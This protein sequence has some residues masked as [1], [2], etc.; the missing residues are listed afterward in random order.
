MGIAPY[1]RKGR[2]QGAPRRPSLYDHQ[3][4][5]IYSSTEPAYRGAGYNRRVSNWYA[6]S[7]S[8]NTILEG[9]LSTLRPRCRDM[10]RKAPWAVSGIQGFVTS[11]VGT[12]VQ[13]LPQIEDRNLRKT[14]MD[15]WRFWND[16]E[17]DADGLD[18]FY[19]LQALAVM[20]QR[21]V[22]ECFIR[23]RDRRPEDG[24]SVPLQLQVLESEQCDETYSTQLDPTRI[25]RLGVEFDPI[26]RRNAYWMWKNH[27]GDALFGANGSE[28]V[29]VPAANVL[30]FFE[31]IRAG[32]VR[33]APP[34]APILALLKDFLDT[35]DGMRARIHVASLFAGF[36]R[37]PSEESNPLGAGSEGVDDDDIPLSKLEAGMFQEL[38]P[39]EDVSFSDPPDV[40]DNF[41][42]WYSSQLRQLA[43]GGFNVTYEM[44][45]GD[46]TKVNYS[47]IRAGMIWFRRAI[48]KFQRLVLIK[49]LCQP[50]WDRWFI[51]A[52]LSG[53]IP[54]FADPPS[55][56]W[57][58]TPGWGYV[59]PTKEAASQRDR[60]RSGMTTRSRTV[61]EDGMDPDQLDEERAR[62]I[63]REEQLGLIYDT[64]P[65]KIDG[66]GRKQM[67]PTA[68]GAAAKE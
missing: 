6:T 40:G 3:G 22:G 14:V 32:Q 13:P 24:L 36:L 43:M 56:M 4:R 57:I 68:P 61:L 33:G 23:L 2:A 29:A 7:S 60:I 9:H 45:T 66:S 37:K 18:S 12:G 25:I 63:A 35:D 39:G 17:A 21:E 64:Q 11:C 54:R 15:A 58:P 10:A 53:A 59:D 44:L 41:S 55:V 26:G 42:E 19:G 50:I 27:P 5:P 28:R 34:L 31:T 38:L 46:L 16:Y 65:E 20:E 8:I 62:E 49:K 47:S 30:H 52:Q 48:M 51:A 67:A 1:T